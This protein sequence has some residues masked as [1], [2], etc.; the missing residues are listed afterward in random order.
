MRVPVFM[1]HS[2]AAS[3]EFHHTFNMK[4]MENAL[5][6]GKGI[7]FEK[8]LGS[9]KVPTEVAH[10][11]GVYVSRLRKDPSVDHGLMM[12]IVADNLRKGA[13]L[14]AI[15]IAEVIAKDYSKYVKKI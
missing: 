1:C 10:E 2:V 4:E 5:V 8:K 9:Y 11:D 14:N 7:H 15:Q 6:H 13:A 3:V 12:W